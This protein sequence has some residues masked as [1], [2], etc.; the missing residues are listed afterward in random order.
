MKLLCQLKELRLSC[1]G[2]CGNDYENKRKLMRDIRKNTL[3][4]ENSKS[5][6]QFMSRTKNLRSSGVCANI[7]YKD[8]KFYCP[9]HIAIHKSKDYRDLD[10]DCEKEHLCKTCY[11]FNTWG[12]EKQ[13]QFLDFIKSKKLDSYTYSIRMDNNSLLKEF[14]KKN[15]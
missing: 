2:C 14:E 13:E 11:L 1:F 4:F 9:G 10:P 15:K 12:K 6:K 8:G 7:I 3:Q 5:I